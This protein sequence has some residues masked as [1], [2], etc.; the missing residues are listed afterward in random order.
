MDAPAWK[1]S[2]SFET[3]TIERGDAATQE[4]A[5]RDCSIAYAKHALAGINEDKLA[6][7]VSPKVTA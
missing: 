1:W 7:H 2:V 4:Q 3:A 6:Y 5:E